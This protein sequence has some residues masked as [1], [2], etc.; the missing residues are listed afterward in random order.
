MLPA[1]WT[2]EFVPTNDTAVQCSVFGERDFDLDD[3][4]SAGFASHT[5][6]GSYASNMVLGRCACSLA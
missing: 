2:A 6:S 4:D 1:G 5:G 3:G